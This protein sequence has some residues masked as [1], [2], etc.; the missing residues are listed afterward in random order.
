M[1]REGYLPYDQISLRLFESPELIERAAER[2]KATCDRLGGSSTTSL[3][4]IR[5]VLS[6][7]II[8]AL[9]PAS[10]LAMSHDGSNNAFR[11]RGFLTCLM[12]SF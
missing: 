3:H 11:A 2:L 5:E 7:V 9:L 6:H 12:V 10:V 1:C 8:G 4:V